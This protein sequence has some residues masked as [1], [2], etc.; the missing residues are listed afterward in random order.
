MLR[1]A[2]GDRAEKLAVFTEV[3]SQDKQ[4]SFNDNSHFRI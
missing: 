1:K 4:K 3:L 2:L